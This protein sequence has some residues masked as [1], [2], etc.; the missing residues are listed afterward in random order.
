M[1]LRKLFGK[2]IPP[3]CDYC[4]YC[5]KNNDGKPVCRYGSR[6]FG[7]PCSKYSYDPLKREPKVLPDIPKYTADDFKL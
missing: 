6:G 5:T 4:L 1:S 3:D 2:N 7:E